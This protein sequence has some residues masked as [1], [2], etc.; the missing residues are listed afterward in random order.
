MSQNISFALTGWVAGILTTLVMGFAWQFAFP[1]IVNVEHYYGDGPS[2]IT[3]IGIAAL[4]MSPAALA[5]GII[6][7]RISVEGGEIGRRL[8]AAI[9]GVFLTMPFACVVLMY[10][11]GWGFGIS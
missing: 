5:G 9:F 8:F 7:G 11:T 1:G 4:V 3:I 10:F 2:L 6:G